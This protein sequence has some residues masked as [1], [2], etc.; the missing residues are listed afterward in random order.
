MAPTLAVEDLAV[1]YGKRRAVEG[2]SLTVGRGEIVTL[3]GGNGSGKSTT[4][5]AISGLVRPARGRILYEG[6]DITRVPADRIVAAGVSHV[7]EGREV[8][9]EFTVRENLLVGGHTAP[10]SD[11]APR[12]EGAFQLFPV[13]RARQLQLAGTLSG[14]EQ[15]MLAIARALMTRPRL[16]LLDEPSLGLAPRLAREIFRTIQRINATGVAVLLVEQNARR[17]LRLAGRGYVLET[18]RVVVAGTSR[19][20]GEDPRVRSAYLGLGTHTGAR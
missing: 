10:R 16:L 13:L 6:R 12:L 14:G 17:A 2:V 4:L 18:G 19:D 7:P 11:V 9:T 15:Q 20:L 1:Y 8:F 5:R 3:L